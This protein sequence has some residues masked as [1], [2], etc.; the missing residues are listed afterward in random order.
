MSAIF[1]FVHLD[2]Q[3]ASPS[4]LEQMDA[5]LAHHGAD[6]GG[7]WTQ[8]AIGLGQRQMCFTPQDRWERQPS[9]SG[10]G[11]RVLVAD[12]RLDNR[13]ELL[14]A[15]HW[16]A[17]LADSELILRAYE[18]WGEDC[19]DHLIGFFAFALWDGHAG[20]LLV[21]RSPIAA[22]GL[23]YFSTPQTFAFATAPSG[24]HALGI[25]PRRINEEK[26]ADMLVQSPA[27]PTA[28]LYQEI[29]RLPT[30]HCLS[31]GPEGLR[32]RRYWWPDAQREI[33]FHRDEEYVAAFNELLERVTADSLRSLTSV[34]L[35]LSGG[36]DSSAL[37]ATAASQ[38]LAKGQRLTAYTEVPRPGFDGPVVA[39][40]YAD[41]TPLVQAI[42]DM[43]E[44]LDLHLICT[45]GRSF[46]D[47]L[48]PIF[49]HLETPFR[50]TTNRLWIQTIFEQARSQGNRVVLDGSQGNLTISWKGSGVLP[51][52]V[53]AGRWGEA[54]RVVRAS[55]SPWRALIGQGILPLLPKPL[56]QTVEWLR[57]KAEASSAQPWRLWSPI[58]PDFAAAQRVEERAKT[59][60]HDFH[61]R[62]S[63]DSW[64]LRS[65]ALASQDF[66]FYASAWRSLYGVD[67]RSPLA[68]VRLAEFCLALPEAQ[69]LYK[70]EARS[71]VRRAMA[72]RLPGPVLTNRRRGMQAA[73]W[74][75]SL[76]SARS[77]LLAAVDSLQES[78]LARHALDLPRMRR[79]VNEWPTTGWNTP[80]VM[81]EYYTLLGRGLTVGHFLRWFE[82]ASPK[83]GV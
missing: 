30:G 56:W 52:L 23:V 9:I 73:D 33:R 81:H 66:G 68:D 13:R 26:L 55:G 4:R 7:L 65:Q 71:L 61:Y 64:T 18:K 40:R 50:N 60:Q 2:K 41:E 25:V 39:G 44:N 70:G 3:P 54:L 17:T 36:L 48:E 24:L 11:Q 59:A 74:H 8:A 31:L 69:F 35:M 78:G 77:Q 27:L 38:L 14:A 16:P 42:A 49:F 5:A 47:E 21:A 58:L 67:S 46:L 51:G 6:G 72:G 63:R 45:Q 10:D 22:P 20:R 12:A 82:G 43:H 19:V 76:T 79:L 37:A 80:Q 62:E 15:G 1:G 83:A 53:G 28:T 34:G 32:T 75:E 29:H 57:G